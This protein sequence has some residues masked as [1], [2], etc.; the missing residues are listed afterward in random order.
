MKVIIL[1]LLGYANATCTENKECL[2]TAGDPIVNTCGKKW[3]PTNSETEPTAKSCIPC[4]E[5]YQTFDDGTK[6]KCDAPINCVAKCDD[7]CA[8]DHAC[9]FNSRLLNKDS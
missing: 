6:T 1:A 8:K 9:A 2:P 5:C 3:N 4:T 7:P